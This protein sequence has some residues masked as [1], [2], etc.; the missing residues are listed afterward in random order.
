MVNASFVFP[1]L[2]I[3]LGGKGQFYVHGAKEHIWTV[4]DKWYTGIICTKVWE[5]VRKDQYL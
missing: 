4:A 1:S 3:L 5:P 2:H